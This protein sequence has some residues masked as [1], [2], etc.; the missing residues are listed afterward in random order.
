MVYSTG[1]AGERACWF[2][3]Q[4]MIVVLGPFQYSDHPSNYYSGA[5]SLT[6]L[7]VTPS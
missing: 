4:G 6:G 5:W 2:D 7:K 3:N 1:N